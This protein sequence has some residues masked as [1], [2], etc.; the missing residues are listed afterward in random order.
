MKN[1]TT[2][3]CPN[4]FHGEI[5]IPCDRI[6]EVSPSYLIDGHPVALKRPRFF[7]RRIYDP[8]K[9]EKLH[10]GILLKKQH[11]DRDP[12]KGIL[13]FDIHFFFPFPQDKYKRKSLSHQYYHIYKPDLSNLI[14]L[15]EDVCVDAEIIKDDS[16]I[17]SVFSVKLYDDNPRTTFIITNIKSKS[18]EE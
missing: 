14:K 15:V 7:D 11:G 8:Q 9:A 16:I 2:Q 3:N 17:S 5:F 1:C 13:H 18:D 6:L 4:R 12:Y 10:R